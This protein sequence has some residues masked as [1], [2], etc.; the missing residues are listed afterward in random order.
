MTRNTMLL[1]CFSIIILYNGK[2]ASKF[3]AMQRKF[4]V[5]NWIMQVL[6]ETVNVYMHSSKNFFFN[7]CCCYYY[8]REFVY[9]A[10]T[11]NST[12]IL[13][14][15]FFMD[16]KN[17]SLYISLNEYFLLPQIF[18]LLF[19]IEEKIFSLLLSSRH[20]IPLPMQGHTLRTKKMMFVVWNIMN[21]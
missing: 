7:G 13:F 21:H 19:F 9:F 2:K 16:F 5:I 11:E 8:S 14:A 12:L 10:L 18:S 15:G 20:A 4:M 17:T 6:V 3:I 1:A